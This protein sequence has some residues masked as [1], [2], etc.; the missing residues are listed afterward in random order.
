MKEAITIPNNWHRVKVEDISLRIHYGYTASS[1]Q[2]NTGTKLLRITDIQNYKVDWDGVPFCEISAHNIEKYLLKENDI[3]FARTGATVGKSFL[4]QGNIPKSVFA[5]YLIRIQLSKLINPQ[6]LFYY[7]QS[8]DY[9]KQIGMKSMGIG[10]PS[11]NASS[12]SKISLL[13]CS[14]NEQNQIVEIIEGLL[15]E[16]DSA[17]DSLEKAANLLSTYE[18]VILNHAFEGKLT[19]KWR[20]EN[21][22]ETSASS[23]KIVNLSSVVK[24]FDEKRIPLSQSER[25]RRPGIYPYYGATQIIDLIDGYIFDGE[26]L[27]IGEDGANLISKTKQLAFIVNGKFWVN[28]HAHVLQTKDILS[29]KYLQYYFNTLDL[30]EYIS[31]TA[32]P[33]LNQ[34]NLN[35]IPVP[36]CE[37]EEQNQIIEEIDSRFS[38]VDDLKKSILKS[39]KKSIILKQTILSKAFSGKLTA[40]ENIEENEFDLLKDIEKEKRAFLKVEKEAVK[41]R[42][43][44]I[45]VMEE[46]KS[47]LQVLESAIEPMSAKEVWLQSKHKED[48]E[49]FYSEL[50]E[51]QNK[52][53]EIKKDTES[54][55]SLR[56]EN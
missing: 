53:I 11:V 55:L 45:R 10:Q 47:I 49:S 16:L 28:N 24:N 17:N 32:Q 39:Q 26:Y 46:K 20:Q 38:I 1:V 25:I 18:H 35:R 48:I 4:I 12:L 42:P 27:L 2:K 19:K 13:L 3:V 23:W 34:S 7:F 56:H 30:K 33:K 44:A 52:I 5:S 40:Q 9:W 29:L 37:L 54:L 8:A 6:Y 51:I 21:L 50:R 43:K 31:G 22:D 36:L 14:R 41:L 15:D